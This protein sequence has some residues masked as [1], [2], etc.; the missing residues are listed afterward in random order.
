L[1]FVAALLTACIATYPGKLDSIQSADSINNLSAGSAPQQTVVAE[2]TIRDYSELIATQN[3]EQSAQLYAV[4]A[5][6]VL[7]AL[8]QLRETRQLRSLLAEAAFQKT[9]VC[10]PQVRDHE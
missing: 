1:V 7:I 9:L 8:L 6:L 3:T 10:F 4:I 2:W 5:L